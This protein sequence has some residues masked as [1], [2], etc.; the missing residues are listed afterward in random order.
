MGAEIPLIPFKDNLEFVTVDNNVFTGRGDVYAPFTMFN[1]NREQSFLSLGEDEYV[2]ASY[3]PLYDRKIWIFYLK[4]NL[5]DKRW[6]N[7]G[8]DIPL[9]GQGTL[10]AS[11][12]FT[13]KFS[14]VNLPFMP[15]KINLGIN[16]LPF[17]K[18][19]IQALTG[20]IAGVEMTQY[21]AQ[22]NL[23]SFDDVDNQYL[24][25]AMLRQIL[26]KRINE[27]VGG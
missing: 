23:L 3:V 14:T 10:L 18:P 12:N 16:K 21:R 9:Y 2:F 27:M 15:G 22:N 24:N 8:R 4:A 13:F 26:R 19:S 20:E 17:T 1:I 25:E 11:G 7:P 6:E 5:L